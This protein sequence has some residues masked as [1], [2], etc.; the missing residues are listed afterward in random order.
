MKI[1]TSLARRMLV[2]LRDRLKAGGDCALAVYGGAVPV[3]ADA[4][5]PNSALLGYFQVG[6]Y[7]IYLAEPT[8]NTLHIAAGETWT[9]DPQAAGTATYFRLLWRYN[10][11]GGQAGYDTA[12]V[13]RLQ[14][15]VGTSGADLIMADPVF[16]VGTP[17]EIKNFV[18]T[19]PLVS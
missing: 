15:T 3:D 7:G 2:I 1:S 6:S 11:A 13:A 12:P 4:P 5:A 8:D 18:L 19:L 14:G 17:K 10:D 16:A 9:C